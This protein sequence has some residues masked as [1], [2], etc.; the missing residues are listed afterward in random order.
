MPVTF[1][2]PST[3]SPLSLPKKVKGIQKG[4][5]R[6][7]TFNVARLG[8]NCKCV[9]LKLLEA[10]LPLL[11]FD[12]RDA[13]ELLLDGLGLVLGRVLFQRLGSAIDQVLGFLQTERSDFANG[14]D[15][16][17][18]VRAGILEDDLELGLLNDFDCRS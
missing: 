8:R 14:L 2:F 18:L 12:S 9:V 10:C 6:R 11:D 1:I 15:G 13:F 17:D 7:A 3:H 5:A 4:T 16:A